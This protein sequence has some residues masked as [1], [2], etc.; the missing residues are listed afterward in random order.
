MRKFAF[1][2]AAL[3][4]LGLA[5]PVLTAPAQA[6]DT[7]IVVKKHRPVHKKIV[8]KRHEP[9]TKVVIKKH[10]PRHKKV[11]IKEHG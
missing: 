5:A 8:I 1:A 3:A 4:A 11:I 2:L 6:Q 7:K 9:S 10:R